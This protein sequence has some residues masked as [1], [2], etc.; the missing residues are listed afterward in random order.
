MMEEMGIDGIEV[1]CG[2]AEDGMSTIRGDLPI[3]AIIEDLGMFKKQPV[4]RFI[5]RHFGRKILKA[6]PFSEEF[7]L[8]A[9]RTIKE[10]VK[11][12]VF[13]VGGNIYPSKIRGIVERGDADYV[14]LCRPLIIEPGFPRQIE[15]GRTEPSRCIH[16]NLCIFYLQL[17]PLRC[18]RGKRVKRD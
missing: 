14:S 8:D 12:P 4:M 7:N 1:S 3:E 16:C 9:A 18:Y 13:A 5:M 2:I 6:L 17:G 11:I 10:S 15:E